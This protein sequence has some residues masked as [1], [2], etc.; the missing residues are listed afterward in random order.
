MLDV[1]SIAC[2]GQIRLLEL[3][4]VACIGG[5]WRQACSLHLTSHGIHRKFVPVP[6]E[7]K[8]SEFAYVHIKAV[9]Y[10]DAGSCDSRK[11]ARRSAYLRPRQSYLLC[12]VLLRHACAMLVS[13]ALPSTSIY[14][15]DLIVAF[16]M[17]CIANRAG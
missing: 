1:T 4:V 11:D 3:V 16:L 15:C 17:P 12:A 10:S 8:D 6:P 9:G 2:F 13:A 14:F 7:V 5:Q